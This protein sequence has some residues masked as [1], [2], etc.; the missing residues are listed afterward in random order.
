MP[1]KRTKKAR[2]QS[3]LKQ[4]S[5]FGRRI[6]QFKLVSLL[7]VFIF[8]GIGAY[9]VFFSKADTG[10]F[11]KVGIH[12]Q[13]SVQPTTT[14]KVIA[15]L[16]SWNGKLYAGYGDYGANTGPT[17]LTPFDGASFTATPEF[18]S[19]THGIYRFSAINGKLYGAHAQPNGADYSVGTAGSSTAT[20][21]QKALVNLA[22]AFDIVTL[23]GTDL[24]MV[25]GATNS[26]AEVWRSTDGGN[27]WQLALGLP[28]AKPE[29]T[30][31]ASDGR[32]YKDF[33][34]FYGIGAYQ[35]KLYVQGQDYCGWT[36]P[37]SRVSSD[38]GVTW[39]TGPNFGLFNHAETF[40]GKMVFVSGNPHSGIGGGSLRTFDGTNLEY[41]AP[42]G[43][44]DYTIDGDS[45][46][47]LGTDNKVWKT[48]NLDNWAEVA[49]A[50]TESRSVGIGRS[51]AILNGTIYL[52]GKDS[53]IY[54]HALT[55]G[56][57]S[58]TND[59]NA[60]SVVISSPANNSFIGNRVNIQAT[61]ADNVKVTRM[62]IYVG[63]TLLK[64]STSGS[65]KYGWNTKN[66]ISGPHTITV[67]AYDAAGN[68]GQASITVNK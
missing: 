14:G 31:T 27:S 39:T 8:A 22:H 43:I 13:A 60:P 45:L 16:K 4:I 57:G 35:G 24:Y 32:T 46:Y 5:V 1:K 66:T 62:E 2:K 58:A 47:I 44:W 12:P 55:S 17:Y 49:I 26:K 38:G 50:P 52:G 54:K 33:S 20:W 63:S 34:R 23:N 10:N 64:T 68:A 40:A 21:E 59:T 6:S 30:C 15:T 36:Q 61:A 28:P 41:K 56:G 65:I 18:T 37:E 48:T 29:L 51:I 9:L 67:K 7:A 3:S 11:V 53:A 19:A 25:G 42:T